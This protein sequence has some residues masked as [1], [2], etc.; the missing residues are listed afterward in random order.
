MS[1][2]P[3]HQAK[4]MFV[5]DVSKDERDEEPDTDELKESLCAAN[6]FGSLVRQRWLHLQGSVQ[7]AKHRQADNS[8]SCPAFSV[9]AQRQTASTKVTF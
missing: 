6:V 1:R 3:K 8:V 9:A 4:G 7:A 2:N 5:S